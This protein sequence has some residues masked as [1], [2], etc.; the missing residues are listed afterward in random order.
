MPDLSLSFAVFKLTLHS[1]SVWTL[2]SCL[3]IDT[4]YNHVAHDLRN[5][6][7]FTVRGQTYKLEFELVA[8]GV[9]ALFG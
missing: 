6:I 7:H 4:S 1:V 9:S 3:P 2:H 5:P 8:V